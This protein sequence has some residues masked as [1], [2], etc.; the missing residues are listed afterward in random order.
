MHSTPNLRSSGQIASHSA[1][2]PPRSPRQNV[3]SHPRTRASRSVASRA[4]GL[5]YGPPQTA[6]RGTGPSLSRSRPLRSR[7]LRGAPHIAIVGAGPIGLE[8]AFAAA[9]RGW[10]FTLYEAMP[11]VAG[12]V[13][14]WGHVQ[15]FTPWELS[16]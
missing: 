11:V 10:P 12:H 5:A 1:P 16:A 6:I 2:K 15:L 3:R 9:E 14:E 13:R 4:Y 8:A 7:G